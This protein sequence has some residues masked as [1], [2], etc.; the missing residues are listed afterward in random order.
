[1]KNFITRFSFTTIAGVLFSVSPTSW[2]APPSS[3]PPIST[4]SGGSTASPPSCSGTCGCSK[5][6]A[7]AG[8]QITQQ[9]KTISY[10]GDPSNC[11][12]ASICLA[13]S[14]GG[15]MCSADSSTPPMGSASTSSS[16]PSGST[17]PTGPSGGAPAPGQRS[18]WK[19]DVM[20]SD[21]K[22]GETY[23]KVMSSSST[24]QGKCIKTE[25]LKVENGG[26]KN[27]ATGEPACLGQ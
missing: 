6:S 24:R 14:S 10:S 18:S 21:C 3:A 4:S 8:G 26:S 25:C 9:N 19:S 5:T 23:V 27:L 17:G 20:P 16:P 1:M 22:P 2:A 11:D 15:W 7:V 13:A 12:P